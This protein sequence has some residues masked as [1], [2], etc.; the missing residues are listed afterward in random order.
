MK[1]RILKI[2]VDTYEC[3]IMERK[4]LVNAGIRGNMKKKE[5]LLVG[6]IVEL[7]QISSR[8]LITSLYERKN[9]MIRPPVSN[10]DKL[11]IISSISNP[12]IDFNLL[13]KQL[14][15]CMKNEIKP[16]ICVSKMDLV[17][18][19]FKLNDKIE[20]IKRVYGNIGI[21]LIFV[22]VKNS[23]SI[24]KLKEIMNGKV[25]ALS[26]N[27]GVGKSSITKKIIGD[28]TIEIGDIGKKSGRGKHTTKYVKLYNIFNNT[29]LLDTPGFSSYELIDISYKELKKYYIEFNK[30]KCDYDDCMH[31]NED[32]SVCAIKKAVENGYI[33]KKRYERYVEFYNKL[34]IVDDRKYK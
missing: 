8:Y 4:L 29:Y 34:K 3:E 2:V 15:L 1:A 16:V 10:I 9:K 23:S 27:S 17:D 11:L 12:Q 18:Q 20:Y 31:V 21:E 5:C 25:C 24:E 6:D 26:G 7:E 28:N 30:F 32:E 33:D 14:I 19:N 13:D 22:S